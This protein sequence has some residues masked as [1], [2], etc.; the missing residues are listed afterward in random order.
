[1]ITFPET[2]MNSW[3]FRGFFL[4]FQPETTVNNLQ[5]PGENIYETSGSKCTLYSADG[6]ICLIEIPNTYKTSK[7]RQEE[8]L[9]DYLYK[10]FFNDTERSFADA[11]SEWAVSADFTSSRIFLGYLWGVF[12]P[13]FEYHR[14]LKIGLGLAVY[15]A[16]ISFKLNLC[17]EF[18][19]GVTYINPNSSGKQPKRRCDDKTEIRHQP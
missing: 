19:T 4:D 8:K 13:A 10:D 9:R 16:D 12:I 6:T 15:E 1:M 14:F 7:V 11:N 17:S 3:S 5:P 18:H 2:R